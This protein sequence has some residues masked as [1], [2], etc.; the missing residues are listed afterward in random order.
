MVGIKVASE[1]VDST[2]KR[3]DDASKMREKRA[4]QRSVLEKK[5][6]YNWKHASKNRNRLLQLICENIYCEVTSLFWYFSRGH[7]FGNKQS[8]NIPYSSRVFNLKLQVSPIFFLLKIPYFPYFQLSFSGEPEYKQNWKETKFVQSKMVPFIWVYKSVIPWTRFSK[9]QLV[10]K[11][12]S[13]NLG[14]P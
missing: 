14:Y 8:W 3:M 2:R 11:I 4:K 6:K 7:F 5:R 12:K 10:G 13:V 9:S 1:L